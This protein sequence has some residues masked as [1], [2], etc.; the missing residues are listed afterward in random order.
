ML[1]LLLVWA[2]HYG[3]DLGCIKEVNC[4][5][6]TIGSLASAKCEILVLRP[7]LLAARAREDGD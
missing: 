2:E 7:E 3:G 5:G 1:F 6:K 4:L